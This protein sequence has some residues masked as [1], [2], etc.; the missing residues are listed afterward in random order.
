M[1]EYRNSM[2]ARTRGGTNMERSVESTDGAKRKAPVKS[3]ED[4]EVYRLSFDSAMK[5]FTASKAFPTEERYSLTDQL[6]R[7]SRSV[8]AN[9]REGFAKRRFRSVFARHLTDAWGSAEETRT[10][11]DFALKCGYL[12]RQ[13]HQALSED[14]DRISAMLFR[15]QQQ[16]T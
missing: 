13:V 3:V 2:S 8:P 16:W 12:P 7:S 11:L 5:V 14:Y 1:P 6:R 9:V 10:W 15:L 4:L